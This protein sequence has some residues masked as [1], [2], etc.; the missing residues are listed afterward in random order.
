MY[1]A[2]KFWEEMGPNSITV[3][4]EDMILKVS[5]RFF[6]IEYLKTILMQYDFIALKSWFDGFDIC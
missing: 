5:V 3:L 4:A 1:I 6:A 2:D